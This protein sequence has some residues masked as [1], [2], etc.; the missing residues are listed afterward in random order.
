MRR[1]SITAEFAPFKEYTQGDEMGMR[2]FLRG[3]WLRA[4]PTTL[5]LG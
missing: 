5:R 2:K 1:G 3:R 4:G